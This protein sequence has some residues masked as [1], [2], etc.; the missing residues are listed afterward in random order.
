MTD[1]ARLSSGERD[2]LL[3]GRRDWRDDDWQD[4]CGDP[5]CESCTGWADTNEN[6]LTEERD[7]VGFQLRAALLAEGAS[8]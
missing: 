8:S 2:R 5:F 1:L 3:A 6:T 7:R 4:H